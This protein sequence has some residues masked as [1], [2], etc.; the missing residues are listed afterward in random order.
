MTS[1]DEVMTALRNADAMGETDDAKQLAQIAARM[2]PETPTASA[3][4]STAIPAPRKGLDTFQTTGGGAAVGNPMMRGRLGLPPNQPETD[5]PYEM[6]G[7][8]AE[9]AGRAGLP[10]WAAGGLGVVG[11]MATA[12]AP[13]L[14]GQPIGRTAAPALEWSGKRLMRSV[15]KPSKAEMQSGQGP[16]AIQTVLDNRLTGTTGGAE[17]LKGMIDPI[18]GQ[19]DQSINASSAYVPVEKILSEVRGQFGSFKLGDER[20]AIRKVEGEI[21]SHPALKT[22][23]DEQQKLVDAIASASQAKVAALQD[24]GRFAT[25][26]AQQQNLAHG[27]GV[28]LSPSQP[29]NASFMN[30]GATG[31]RALS[32]SAYA[33][34]SEAPRIA[35][36]YTEN[37]QRVPE[38]AGAQADAMAIYQ[39]RKLEEEVAHKA[40]DDFIAQGKTGIPVK[41]VQELKQKI[42][43][44]LAKSYGE[45]KSPQIEAYK[46]A[47]RGAKVGIE[48]AVPGVG[49][50]N[51]QISPMINA[52]KMILGREATA[53]NKDPINFALL[54]HNLPA[55]AAMQAA[56]SGY[57]KSQLANLLYHNSSAIPASL[58]YPLLASPGL[59]SNLQ[60]HGNY[61]Q[62]A[63]PLQ[64]P[65]SG[66]LANLQ[67]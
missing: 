34:G 12:A 58:L 41:E 44:R 19:I 56:R 21:L 7:K 6:G 22:A 67:R 42:Y 18:K 61:P 15:L 36:R 54:A 30:V 62:P 16:A 66:V 46:A 23:R 24:A 51:A 55:A 43:A 65:G 49:E 37:I 17:K 32:P 31:G 27:G 52:S 20:A 64:S 48:D 5:I 3:A 47:A 59:L 33:G 2:A 38:A 8:V 35:G 57:V 63:P 50:M 45:M 13:M 28:A 4:P 25:T 26:A 10:A 60:Q 40:L 39:Q 14:M 9:L 53:G 29:I 11:N 1:Y